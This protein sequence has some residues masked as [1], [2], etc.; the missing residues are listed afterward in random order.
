MYS[1][2]RG[3]QI[4]AIVLLAATAGLFGFTADANAQSTITSA[5]TGDWSAGA[6]WAGGAAP[7]AG[8]NIILSAGH[9]VTFDAAASG[10]LYGTLEIRDN[11]GI[12]LTK[13]GLS[14]GTVTTSG[15]VG[16]IDFA[17]FVL[18]TGG[19]DVSGD[20]R[21]IDS[22]DT[23]R[24]NNSRPLALGAALRASTNLFVDGSVTISGDITVSGDEGI[25]NFAIG[26]AKTLTYGGD[27]I[28]GDNNRIAFVGDDGGTLDAASGLTFTIGGIVA[29]VD[30]TINA[31]VTWS[32]DGVLTI[33]DGVTVTTDDDFT[34]GENTLTLGDGTVKTLTGSGT[35]LISE[36]GA[37][38]YTAAGLDTLKLMTNIA[39]DSTANEDNDL[40]VTINNT[41]GGHVTT[42][43]LG[44]AD[45]VISTS[46]GPVE[47]EVTGGTDC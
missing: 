47:L 9:T 37:I 27:E 18:G 24:L 4:F 42:V 10:G 19:V 21:L 15:A 3:F 31:P 35:L 45:R 13:N 22:T 11:A 1:K 46:K 8:D 12:A 39:L 16:S 40:S 20:I 43:F 7:A 25:V 34:V 44:G 38:S 14:F 41:D 28:E 33:A 23:G 5:A 36:R 2:G 26:S 17:S 30:I 32:D 6:T 29:N